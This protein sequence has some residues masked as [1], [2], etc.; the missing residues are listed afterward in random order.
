M[1]DRLAMCRCP[2]LGI[3]GNGA[4]IQPVGPGSSALFPTVVPMLPVAPPISTRREPIPMLEDTELGPRE[5]S[6]TKYY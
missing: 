2:L 5:V 3:D 1:N 6:V 4:A